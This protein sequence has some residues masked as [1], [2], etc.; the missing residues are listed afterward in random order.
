MTHSD[1]TVLTEQHKIDLAKRVRP[2]GM[3]THLILTHGVS[4]SPNMTK[5]E[6]GKLHLLAH[7]MMAHPELREL[8]GLK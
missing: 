4:V 6:L 2:P 8:L 1:R 5:G 3:I 7:A